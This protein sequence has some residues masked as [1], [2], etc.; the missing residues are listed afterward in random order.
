MHYGFRILY[1]VIAITLHVQSLQKLSLYKKHTTSND[2][3][4]NTDDQNQKL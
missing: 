2:N 3:A 1:I 4:T